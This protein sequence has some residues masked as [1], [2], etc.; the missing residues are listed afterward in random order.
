MKKKFIL[1]DSEMLQSM[2]ISRRSVNF[3]IRFCKLTKLGRAKITF[4]KEELKQWAFPKFNNT[5][6]IFNL[7]ENYDKSKK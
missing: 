1:F 2:S 5:D 6:L 7:L 4:S 3:I